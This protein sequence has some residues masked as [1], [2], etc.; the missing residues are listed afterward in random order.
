MTDTFLQYPDLTEHTSISPFCLILL[1]GIFQWWYIPFYST[2]ICFSSLL[3]LTQL[4]ALMSWVDGMEYSKKQKKLKQRVYFCR[5]GDFNRLSHF[6]TLGLLYLILSKWDTM[7]NTLRFLSW[8]SPLEELP[9]ESGRLSHLFYNGNFFQIWI[10]KNGI[11]C[12]K[13]G[14][15]LLSL[16]F[17][18]LLCS[19][20]IFK[21]CF[22]QK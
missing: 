1:F 7:V 22:Y 13:V 8:S 5:Y 2:T 9:N 19:S 12:G 17:S 15:D 20:T 21:N 6:I 3:K 16:N 11:N 14:F 18:F 10:R 4:V